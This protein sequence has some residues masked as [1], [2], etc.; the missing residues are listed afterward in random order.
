[1]KSNFFSKSPY[2]E[3]DSFIKDFK[4]LASQEKKFLI[5]LPSI[6]MQL[7]L[8]PTEE[9]ENQLISNFAIDLKVDEFLIQNNHQLVL[10]LLE[11]LSPDGDAAADNLTDIVNDA[12]EMELIQKEKSDNFLQFLQKAKE[13]AIKDFYE[14]R[15]RAEYEQSGLPLIKSI[16]ATA[17][18]RAIFDKPFKSA[19]GVDMYSPKCEGFI[20]VAIIKLQLDSD[21]PLE[22]VFFQAG[23]KKLRVLIDH[24]LS[25]EKQLDLTKNYIGLNIKK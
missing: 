4:R 6:A 1:M 21:S 9:D 23:A 15:R 7:M 14:L 13:L 25:V 24:L 12:L 22:N 20:P 8:E 18:L 3:N 19:Y 5:E 10:Y 17:N 2:L 16:T 11:H